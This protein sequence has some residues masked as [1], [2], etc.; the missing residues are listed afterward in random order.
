MKKKDVTPRE[1]PQYVS[2]K[3]EVNKLKQPDFNYEPW[4]EEF[5]LPMVFA[6]A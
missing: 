1:G 6:P 4:H 5:A 2:L 3:E